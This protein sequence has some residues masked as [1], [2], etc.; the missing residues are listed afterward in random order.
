MPKIYML[1]W[2]DV[3]GLIMGSIWYYE[4]LLKMSI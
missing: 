2:L 1:A 3:L 4:N